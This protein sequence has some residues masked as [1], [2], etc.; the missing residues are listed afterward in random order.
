MATF[1]IAASATESN[2]WLAIL[3]GIPPIPCRLY[4]HQSRKSIVVLRT[5]LFKL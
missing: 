3:L 5:I 2:L 4:V 1:Y